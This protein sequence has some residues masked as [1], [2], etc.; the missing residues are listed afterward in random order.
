MKNKNIFVAKKL[1]TSK[2]YVKKTWTIRWKTHQSNYCHT[3]NIQ[4]CNNERKYPKHQHSKT[5]HEN[6]TKRVKENHKLS[7]LSKKCN[8]HENNLVIFSCFSD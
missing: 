4:T 7:K 3:Q 1:N 2:Q 5:S 6:L 8:H